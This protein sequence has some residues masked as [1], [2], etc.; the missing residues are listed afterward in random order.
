M[1]NLRSTLF[2]I[3]SDVRGRNSTVILFVLLYLHSKREFAHRNKCMWAT[4]G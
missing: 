4:H 3:F 2:L 1:G